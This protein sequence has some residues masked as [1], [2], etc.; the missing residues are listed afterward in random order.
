MSGGRVRRMCSSPLVRPARARRLRVL[1]AAAVAVPGAA[2]IAH[3][4]H[5]PVSWRNA[6]SGYFSDG[7]NWSGGFLP[8]NTTGTTYDATIGL[9]GS[10]TVTFDINDVIDGLTINAPGATLNHTAGTLT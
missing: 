6:V 9:P 2:G 7:A 3:G 1:A 10:Y 4:N 5:V 8:Y